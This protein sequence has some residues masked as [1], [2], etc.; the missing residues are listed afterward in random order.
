MVFDML[1]ERFPG[2]VSFAAES[3]MTGHYYNWDKNYTRR[4][5]TDAEKNPEGEKGGSG[6]KG[7]RG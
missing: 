1:A 2:N 7:A 3:H 4:E 5:R 6:R